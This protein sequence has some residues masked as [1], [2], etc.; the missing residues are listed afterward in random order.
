MATLNCV[1]LNHLVESRFNGEIN[2]SIFGSSGVR[3]VVWSVTYVTVPRVPTVHM[4]SKCIRCQ[5]PSS[6]NNTPEIII[7]KIDT[8][9]IH[10]FSFL[11]LSPPSWRGIVV[12][13]RWCGWAGGCQTCGTHISVTAWRI[14]SIRSS[15]E[16]SRP[17]VVHYHGHLPICLIWACPWAK[18]LSNL[19]QTLWNAYLWNCWMNPHR[20]S[21]PETKFT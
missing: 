8:Y 6:I 12:T 7:S 10:G 21:F 4:A 16:L 2:M 17:L 20:A 19:P 3:H 11:P 18:N 9:S 1:Y 14:F 5:L 15:V 13:V